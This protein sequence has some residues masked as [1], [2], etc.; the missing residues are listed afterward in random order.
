LSHS[1]G[2]LFFLIWPDGSPRRCE[3][4]F[5]ELSM[6]KLLHPRQ[7]A[8]QLLSISLRKID[9]LISSKALKTVRVGRRNLVAHTELGRFASIGTGKK[10]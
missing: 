8:A 10:L 3:I 7:E 9:L 1:A 2:L 5:L 6:E 4:Q